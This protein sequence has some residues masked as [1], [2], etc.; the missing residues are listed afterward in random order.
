ML[1]RAES[2]TQLN[3]VGDSPKST[4]AK[5]EPNLRA[6]EVFGHL[7]KQRISETTGRGDYSPAL[8]PYRTSIPIDVIY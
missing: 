8:E 2:E 3:E 1:G 7:G 6:Q 5:L 4:E